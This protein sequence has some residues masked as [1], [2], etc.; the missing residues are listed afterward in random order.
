MLATKE[1]LDSQATRLDAQA[2]R[3]REWRKED[4]KLAS[5]SLRAARGNTIGV[6]IGVGV[7]LVMSICS[8]IWTVYHTAPPQQLHTG[9]TT[10]Q[11]QSGPP[12]KP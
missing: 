6:W 9:G 8:F 10:G 3:E 5:N 4:M 2:E 1:M 12:A 7:A 11:N